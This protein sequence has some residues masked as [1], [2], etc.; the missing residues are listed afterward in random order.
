MTTYPHLELASEIGLCP[1]RFQKALSLLES[2][3]TSGQFTGACI[4]IGRNLRSLPPAAFGRMRLD[5]AGAKVH[6]DTIFLIAS[7]TKP[8]TCIA[9]AMLLERGL[10]TL[11]QRADHFLPELTEDKKDIR[12]IHLLTHTSG[13]PDMLPNNAELRAAHASLDSFLEGIYK[14]PLEFPTGTRVQ[15]QSMG[16]MLLA[17]IARRVSGMSLQDFLADEV[18][19]PL[20]MKDSFLGRRDE[21]PARISDV[22]LPDSAVG[23]DW[24]WNSEYW[25]KLGVPWGGMFSNVGDYCRLLQMMLNGGELEGARILSPATADLMIRNHLPSLP[26]LPDPERRGNSWGLG[27][28][29]PRVGWSSYFGDLLSTRA[30]GHGGASGT[31]VWADPATGLFCSIFTN[32]PTIEREL[33]VISNAVASSLVD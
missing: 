4:K 12:L 11:D 2:F 32:Q 25:H 20:G 24:N 29:K 31:S 3:V 27:W 28:M 7:P 21:D 22:R 13:L 8:L 17:E 1:D 6:P 5:D 18:F 19:S 23:L 16:I 10:L 15:Y 33:G 26:A 9:I 14:V 30:F